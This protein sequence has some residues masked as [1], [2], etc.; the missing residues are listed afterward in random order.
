MLRKT[1]GQRPGERGRAAHFPGPREG[2]TQGW[3]LYATQKRHLSFL[4]A[5]ACL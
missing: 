5:H 2:A 3:P 1:L 4:G